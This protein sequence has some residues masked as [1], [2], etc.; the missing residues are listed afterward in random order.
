MFDLL[1][2][3]MLNH[4]DMPMQVVKQKSYVARF[5]YHDSYQNQDVCVRVY[6]DL[7]VKPNAAEVMATFLDNVPV[8]T[9]REI[10]DLADVIGGCTVRAKVTQL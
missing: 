1:T 2:M 9:L 10:Q 6:Y 8:V 7:E 5:S 4:A 3:L